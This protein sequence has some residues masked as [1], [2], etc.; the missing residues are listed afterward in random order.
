M[1]VD[2][3]ISLVGVNFYFM[4][5]TLLATYKFKIVIFPV[6]L[7]LHHFEINLLLIMLSWY[8]KNI[9]VGFCSLFLAQSSEN[10]WHLPSDKN[11][12]CIL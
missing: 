6:N 2:Q 7:I 9:Y 5:C 8:N 10:P 3:Y 4:Y 12:F 1:I 11:I